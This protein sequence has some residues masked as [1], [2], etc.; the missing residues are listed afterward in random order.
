LISKNFFSQFIKDA[1]GQNTAIVLTQN[2]KNLSS[3]LKSASIHRRPIPSAVALP[4]PSPVL[5]IAAGGATCIIF[6]DVQPARWIKLAVNAAWNPIFA[7]T[8]CDDANYLE[9][10]LPDQL[11]A[12]FPPMAE[13]YH[14]LLCGYP[15]VVFEEVIGAADEEVGESKA[16]WSQVC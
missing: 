5:N 13:I 15:D 12:S 11:T 8:R 6:P 7:P 14:F 10:F 3:A 1:V 4:S 9:V 16:A 2:E